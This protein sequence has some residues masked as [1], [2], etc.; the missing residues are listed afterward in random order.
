MIPCG[1]PIIIKQKRKNT[2]PQNELKIKVRKTETFSSTNT[3]EVSIDTLS[4]IPCGTPIITKQ[5]R[6]NTTPQNELKIKV[7][8]LQTF[9]ST[10]TEEVIIDTLSLIPCGTAWDQN[11]CAYDAILCI[12]HAMWTRNKDQ[13]THIFNG[14][15]NEILSNLALNFRK[16]SFGLKT[17]ESTRDDMR[18]FLHQLA[19]SHFG[20][21]ELTAASHIIIYMFTL[22]ADTM[23][24]KY[25][26]K[27]NH[28]TQ[29]RTPDNTCLIYAG[30]RRYASIS[31]WLGTMNEETDKSCTICSEQLLIVKEFA[32]PL[33][34][35]ALDFSGQT[36]QIDATFT[37]SI[38]NA[39]T[40]YKLCG[41]IYFG[42][43]HYTACV[44]TDN[45][46]VWFHNGIATGQN[47][48]YEG[49]LNNLSL[50]DCK[51]KAALMAIYLRC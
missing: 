9:A 13:Y 28:V 36:M 6:K 51:G 42:D 50:K 39:E 40:S 12:V 15:N 30:N 26:C 24:F 21:G 35:I 11:S 16:H 1:T 7:R 29:C 27:N 32:F 5:K 47:L 43:A 33:P 18:C 4:L 37:I 17:L 2:T 19:P 41:I 23:V 49:M 48:I 46:M 45:G 3:E 25:R 20:W 14:T 10:N 31:D 22:P 44:V 38:N 34:F 8:K